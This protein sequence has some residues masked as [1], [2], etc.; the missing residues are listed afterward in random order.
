MDED[1]FPVVA[2]VFPL[3]QVDV[4]VVV[5]EDASAVFAIISELSL[6]GLSGGVL[7]LFDIG[8][9]FSVRPVNVLFQERFDDTALLLHQLGGVPRFLHI[10][11]TI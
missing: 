5:F 11:T 2:I 4:S 9:E 6:V 1:A 3:S 8:H 10:L 7:N